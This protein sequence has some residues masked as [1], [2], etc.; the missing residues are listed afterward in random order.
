MA[1]LGTGGGLGGRSAG[2]PGA[3]EVAR[4][5]TPKGAV[6]VTSELLL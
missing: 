3:E 6:R 2:K 5:K 4:T 1:A